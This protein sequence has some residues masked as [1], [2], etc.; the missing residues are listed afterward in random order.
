MLIK[1]FILFLKQLY[2]N[3]MVRD[4][5]AFP[6][7]QHCTKGSAKSAIGLESLDSTEV[8]IVR[9]STEEKNNLAYS[10]LLYTLHILSINITFTMAPFPLSPVNS[11]SLCKPNQHHPSRTFVMISLRS[12][13]HFCR[14]MH[15]VHLMYMCFLCDVGMLRIR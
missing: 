15:V 7:P 2:Q 12:L 1:K 4:V 9:Y 10:F 3:L 8:L 6:S 11:F 5:S 13:F 14:N